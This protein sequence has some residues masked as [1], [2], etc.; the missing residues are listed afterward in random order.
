MGKVE[1]RGQTHASRS[2][3]RTKLAQESFL[4]ALK[5]T[6]EVAEACEIVGI[7][8]RTPYDWSQKSEK[9]ADTM[10]AAAKQGKQT[11][12]AGVRKE[13]KLRG[14][15]GKEE[16]VIH[17]GKVSMI[18]DPETG[19]MVPLKVKKF[20]DVLLMFYAKRLDPEFKDNFPAIDIHSSGPGSVKIV[21][22]GSADDTDG[23]SEPQTID[24]TP[25]STEKEDGGLP[26]LS[27][28]E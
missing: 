15:D 7:A 13:I 27:V 18:E 8:R 2:L 23:E 21:L 17:Q 11:L 19:E 3:K 1:R 9:F 5:T 20:S 22:A 10:E 28:E 26:D 25:E 12:L 4:E 16:L 6:G 24:V 14:L